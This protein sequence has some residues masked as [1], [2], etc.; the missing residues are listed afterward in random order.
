[1]KKSD[2]LALL[3]AMNI[4]A[5]QIEKIATDTGFLIRKSLVEAADILYAICCGS[6]H[7]TVSFNDLAAKIDAETECI[8]KQ[9]GNCKKDGQRIVYSVFKENTGACYYKQNR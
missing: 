8:C 7:G 3:K 9:T 5:N 6:T 2:F 1:M 4:H